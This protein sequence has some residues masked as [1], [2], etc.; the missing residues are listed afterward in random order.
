MEKIYLKSYG[1]TASITEHNDGSAT[2]KTSCGKIKT[3]KKYKSK[4]GALVAWRR[5]CS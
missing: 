1:M 3:K 5:M 2:L 4:R